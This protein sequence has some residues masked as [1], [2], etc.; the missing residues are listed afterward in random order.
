MNI[1]IFILIV[2]ILVA[3][4]YFFSKNDAADN[5]IS[6]IEKD[7]AKVYSDNIGSISLHNDYLIDNNGRK[8]KEL[9]LTREIPR[10]TY[11]LGDLNGKYWGEIDQ[12]SET[13]YFQEKFLY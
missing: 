8:Y 12:E 5:T 13:E 3:L 11:I 7:T 6:E 2:I 4:Y 9:N 10:R 1:G